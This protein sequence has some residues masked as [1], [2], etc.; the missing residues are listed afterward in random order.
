MYI[1]TALT[2]FVISVLAFVIPT[3]VF[4][5]K[6][7]EQCFT[8][9]SRLTICVPIKKLP[10][11]APAPTATFTPTPL[12]TTIPTPTS[13]PLP[14]PTPTD[15]QSPYF[16]ADEFNDTNINVLTW[17]STTNGGYIAEA[18]GN[19]SLATTGNA[20]PYPMVDTLLNPFPLNGNYRT[21]IRFRFSGSVYDGLAIAAS[22]GEQPSEQDFE[23]SPYSN[24][25]NFWMKIG[26]SDNP[27]S[28]NHTFRCSPWE[29]ED[30]D[31][32]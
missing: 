6:P 8:L 3:P 23:N 15:I 30:S 7:D 16:F 29:G 28:R 31:S 24:A 22:S 27:S 25:R 12:P 17:N 32:I 4:A 2:I 20:S 18:D 9:F 13:T 10:K 21:E 14:T 1:K 11:I 5:A 26:G 19:L